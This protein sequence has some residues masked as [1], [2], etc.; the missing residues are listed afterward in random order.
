ML[1]FNKSD[2][3]VKEY[4]KIGIYKHPGASLLNPFIHQRIINL[5]KNDPQ[6]R[7]TNVQA[8]MT[9][10]FIMDEY[11]AQVVSWI[12]TLIYKHHYI[13]KVNTDAVL[14]L[15]LCDCWGVVYNKG[16]YTHSHLHDVSYSFIYYVNT[17]K[18]SSP[19]VLD[20]SRKKIKAESGQAIIMPGR[21]YHSV[22]KNKC[23]GRSVLAGNFHY[24]N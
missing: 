5:S 15:S 20:T 21:I 1:N 12:E 22:P 14:K 13:H 11:I 6:K 8:N 2:F 4:H 18:G 23:E 19:L 9:D 10:W 7:T 3:L 17:P 16:D 24:K